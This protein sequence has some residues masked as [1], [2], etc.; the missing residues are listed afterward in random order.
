MISIFGICMTEVACDADSAE[1]ISLKKTVA[2]DL[3]FS[4][5]TLVITPY[6]L[7]K[8]HNSEINNFGNGMFFTKI[9]NLLA[10]LLVSLCSLNSR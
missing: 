3:L 9:E 7:K 6:C 10:S 2:A 8:A 5:V 1:M 4:K